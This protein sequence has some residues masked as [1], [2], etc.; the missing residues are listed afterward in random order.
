MSQLHTAPAR[1][2]PRERLARQFFRAV[3]PLARWMMSMGIPTGS[4]NIL[5]TVR[6]RR[7]GRPRTTPVSMLELDGRRF[8]Q[9]SYSE[10]GW[11]RNLR[12]AGQATLTDHGRRIAVQ[13]V[14][15]A[16]DQS[17]VILRRALEPYRRSRVLRALLGPRARPPVAV[18]RWCRIR[19]DDTPEEYLAEARRHPL[20]ELRS[21]PEAV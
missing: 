1:T 15:L 7:S 16:T 20:F 9:A 11:V 13:S 21:M 12:A 5:L 19:V 8:V 17:A 10:D 4:R 6:G 2:D 14:E 3:N 18:L